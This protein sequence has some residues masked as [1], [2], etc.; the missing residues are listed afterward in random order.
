MKRQKSGT[1]PFKLTIKEKTKKEKI[2]KTDATILKHLLID[3]RKELSAIAAEL[4][5]SKDVIWQHYTN[6]MKEGIIVGSTIQLNYK[7]LGYDGAASFFI[8]VPPQELNET[9]QRIRKIPGLYD[10]YPCGPSRLW[11][12][13]DF[14]RTDQ[15]DRVKLLINRIPSVLRLQIEIWTDN[16]KMPENLSILEE[17]NY[18]TEKKK[19]KVNNSSVC[20]TISDVDWKLIF[21]LKEDSRAS[22]NEIGKELG[23]STSKVI[24]R[25]NTLKSQGIISPIIQIDLT[26]IGY[27][28]E[29]YFRVRINGED[30]IFTIIDAICKIK[31]ITTVTRTIGTFDLRI[32]AQVKSLEHLL[33]LETEIGNVNGVREMDLPLL[34]KFSVFPYPLEH[35]STL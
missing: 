31:D 1:C 33:D 23:I 29:S 27:F 11:A 30:D 32:V 10:A 35:M 13:S 7:S 9:V 6:L 26:R 24:R 8:D 15:I 34:S 17:S 3:G 16:R 22:Y 28:G 18:I 4:K 2:D 14:M 5:E 21:K 20:V 12:V 19:E 25:Y